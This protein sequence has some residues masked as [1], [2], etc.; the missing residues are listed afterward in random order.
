MSNPSQSESI[1][2]EISSGALVA[3]LIRDGLPV[4]MSRRE[5]APGIVERGFLRQPKEFSS[6]VRALWR[7]EGL[8]TKR[9]RIGIPNQLALCRLMRL[10]DP[11]TRADLIGAIRLTGRETFDAVDLSDSLLGIQELDRD[12]AKLAV[13]V[14]AV[15]RAE[16]T[17]FAKALERAGLQVLSAETAAS[18]QVRA[19]AA[20]LDP[21]EVSLVLS[22]GPD[23]TTVILAERGGVSFLRSV[24]VGVT[25]MTEA[26]GSGGRSHEDSRALLARIGFTAQMPEGIAPEIVSDV[27]NRILEPFD[28]LVQQVGDTIDF[29]RASR[30]APIGRMIVTGEGSAIPGLEAAIA[31]Y[32]PVAPLLP[33][34][35]AETFEGVP[36]FGTFAAALALSAGAGPD[37]LDKP[38]QGRRRDPADGEERLEDAHVGRTGESRSLGHVQRRKRGKDRAIPKPYLVALL[39]VSVGITGMVYG[40]RTLSDKAQER[41]LEVASSGQVAP[42]ASSRFSDASLAGISRQHVDLATP[43]RALDEAVRQTPGAELIRFGFDDGSLT[44]DISGPQSAGRAVQR[45]LESQGLTVAKGSASGGITHLV[46]QP[47]AVS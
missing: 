33:A 47:K 41:R 14:T 23:A 16:L 21:L 45:Q 24:P 10:P 17:L 34:Q 3:A 8:P 9:V 4:T 19:M 32:L 18:A 43:L 27:Q 40:A 28:Q 15:E 37:L 30:Q 1:G 46:I 5:L 29:A 22:I 2:L 6:A 39:A 11:G 20:P 13:S 25:S 38:K 42:P 12:G 35:G 44:G 36:E 26:I 31:Q 7:E